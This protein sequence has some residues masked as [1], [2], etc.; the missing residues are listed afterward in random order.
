MEALHR[1]GGFRF[2]L[3]A[4]T[5]R[6]FFDE[7]I[8][9]LY[10]YHEVSA[11]VGLRQRSALAFDL[12]TTVAAL[13]AMLP[14]DDAWVDSLARTVRDARCRA[15]L[16]DIAPLGVAVAERAEVPSLLV[17]S[18]TWPWIYEP[19]IARAPELRP[20]SEEMGRW[21]ERATWHVQ[22][23]PLCLPSATADLRVPPVGRRARRSRDAVRRSLGLET[24]VGM[25]LQTMGGV[26]EALPFVDRLAAER[27]V[28]FVVTGA[29]MT[30]VRGNLHLFAQDVRLYLPDLVRASDAVVAKM[31]YSTV[32]E[33]WH[34]GRPLAWVTRPDFRETRPL[35]D[36]VERELTGFEIPAP[37]FAGGEWIE[38]V[39]EL[40]AM[41][42]GN[43]HDEGGADMVARF[44]LQKLG[45]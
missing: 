40:L 33:V 7:S 12:P 45:L 20:L 39:P 37:E 1:L 42:G 5:P 10:R 34:E 29:P 18:F 44:F 35:R 41:G 2:E 8:P 9:G 11:D 19:L 23:E 27:H 4:A 15:V 30:R 6:W 24:D 38:R 25:V 31:G 17:E 36:W 14:F 21:L 22:A 16:C 43:P 3:F 28:H 13:Q 32:A 26:P